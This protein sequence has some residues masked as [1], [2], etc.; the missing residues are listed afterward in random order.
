MKTIRQ[1]IKSCEISRK[2][3]FKVFFDTTIE[4]IIELSCKDFSFLDK[5]NS[6]PEIFT[7]VGV[8][9]FLVC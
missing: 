3:S 5:M 6:F 7:L 8:K 2:V 9:H 1:G 4:R